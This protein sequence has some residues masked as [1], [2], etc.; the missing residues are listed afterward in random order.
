[1]QSH[2]IPEFLVKPCYDDKH[3]ARVRA[4]PDFRKHMIQKGYRERLLCQD[5]ELRFSRYEQYFS[6][7]WYGRE[8]LRPTS[9]P[10]F[11]FVLEGIDYSRFKLFHLSLLWRA[12]VS[13]REEYDSVRLGPHAQ[14]LA[15][16]LLTD[17]PGPRNRYPLG[18]VGLVHRPSNKFL[19]GFVVSLGSRRVEGHTVYLFVFG[20]CMW[21]YGVSSHEANWFPNSLSESGCLTVPIESFD[22]FPLMRDFLRMYGRAMLGIK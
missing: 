1:M 4:L 20:G 13:T 8:A 14:R 11:G 3:R 7:V 6:R 12:G 10:A 17:D 19:E 22:E 16:L 5:C 15:K 2:I 21:C 9:A 18:A